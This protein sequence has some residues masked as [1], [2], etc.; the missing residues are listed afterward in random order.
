MAWAAGVGV[1]LPVGVVV[2]AGVG[3]AGGVAPGVTVT[4]GLGVGEGGGVPVG[5]GVAVGGT[6]GVGAGV[7]VGDGVGGTVGVGVGVGGTVGVGDALTLQAFGPRTATV[8]GAPVLKNP[9]V[10]CVAMGAWSES[11]R[12]LYMVPQRMAFA[13]AFNRMVSELQ[14]SAPAV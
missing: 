10:A 5:V 2:A 7:D 13:F 6:V 11:N 9:T 3:E 14:V 4:V 8:I 12:K 1:A